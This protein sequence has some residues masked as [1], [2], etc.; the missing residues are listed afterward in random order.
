MLE[1]LRSRFPDRIPARTSNRI[2]RRLAQRKAETLPAMRSRSGTLAR[3]GRMLRSVRRS[4][5]RWPP[6][7]EPSE[8]PDA[9]EHS[10]KDCRKAMKR[11]AQTERADDFHAW[12]KAVKRLWYQLRLL[13]RLASGMTGQ[14]EEFRTLETALGDEHNLAVFRTRL[15]RDRALKD[16]RKQVEHVAALSAA[17]EEELRRA[18]I[19]LGKRLFDRS[20]K[21]FAR[22][23]ERRLR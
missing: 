3:A 16:A 5:R 23:L 6:S 18:A 15:E 10:C 8:L 13:E 14:V 2:R 4:A 12:R 7:M 1:Q 11:A 17:L 20:P 22:D 21:S 9:L 19:V